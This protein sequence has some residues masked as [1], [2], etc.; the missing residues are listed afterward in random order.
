MTT[1]YLLD[2]KNVLTPNHRWSNVC[3]ADKL[4]ECT[5]IYLLVIYYSECLQLQ[6]EFRNQ[7]M[8]DVSLE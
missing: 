3:M 5:V 2:Q 7:E 8:K 1:G 4:S 6:N